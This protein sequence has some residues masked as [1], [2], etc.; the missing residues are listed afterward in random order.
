MACSLRISEIEK[1]SPHCRT[2]HTLFKAIGDRLVVKGNRTSY[3]VCHRRDLF[4]FKTH[5][6]IDFFFK[7]FF[8]VF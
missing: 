6:K 2:T 4:V 3:C 8:F 1:G 7:R 5:L